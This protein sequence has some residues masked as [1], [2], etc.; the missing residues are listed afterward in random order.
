MLFKKES[1]SNNL[2]KNI[3]EINLSYNIKSLK[4]V[5]KTHK[6]EKISVIDLET[7][8]INNKGSKKKYMLDVEL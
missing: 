6:D 7:L 3:K 8:S 4:E 1:T 5:A 2:L